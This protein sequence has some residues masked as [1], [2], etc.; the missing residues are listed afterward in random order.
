[1][2]LNKSLIIEVILFFYPDSLLKRLE[3]LRNFGTK[4]E[5]YADDIP[6]D[7]TTAAARAAD[8]MYYAYII[9]LVIER[10]I[11]QQRLVQYRN[12]LSDAKDGAP[13]DPL[14]AHVPPTPPPVVP[15]GVNE[16]ILKFV[17]L[18]NVD[19][20]PETIKTDLQIEG[21]KTSIDLNEETI[22]VKKVVA[23]EHGVHV[24]YLKHYYDGLAV[25]V[26]LDGGLTFNE[27]GTY[28]HSP[29]LIT[30]KNV[31]NVPETRIYKFKGT[32]KDQ[33]AG[34][35]SKE[36]AVVTMMY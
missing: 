36:F 27:A 2:K 23:D 4:I 13:L 6:C 21:N 14:S 28:N 22:D 29:A 17:K 32:Y 10:D 31:S 8:C 25:Y 16:R 18:I 33:I 3:W 12:T 9:E 20:T 34:F 19:S 7:P 11:S 24:S 15:A 30:T 5:S 35:F 1:M 26:S